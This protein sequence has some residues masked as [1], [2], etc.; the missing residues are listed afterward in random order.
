MTDA[1]RVRTH[2]DWAARFRLSQG[3]RVGNLVIISGRAAI[4]DDG[5][6]VG[7]GDFSAQARRTLHNVEAVLKAGGSGLDRI[8]KMTTYV[9][10]MAELPRLRPIWNE[11]FRSPYPA[12]TVVGV[13]ALGIAGLMIEI[14]AIG[15]V[16]GRLVD[17]SERRQRVGRNR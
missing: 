15:L 13:S 4:G 14:E 1:Y 16:D 9:T 7:R 12:H 11:L 10:D 6:I 5:E 17:T 2:P 8:V 3:F